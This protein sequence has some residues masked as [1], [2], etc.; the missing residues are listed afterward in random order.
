MQRVRQSWSALVLAPRL[1]LV[2]VP[3]PVVVLQGKKGEEK[4]EN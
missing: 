1:A 2:P 4:E 3:T